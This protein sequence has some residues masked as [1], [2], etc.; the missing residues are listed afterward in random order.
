MEPT[1]LI[2]KEPELRN[3]LLVPLRVIGGSFETCMTIKV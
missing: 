1:R 3:K 2:L